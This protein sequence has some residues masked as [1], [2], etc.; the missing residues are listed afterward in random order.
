MIISI[1]GQA[2]SG[3]SSVA[4]L[5]ANKLGYRRYSIGDLR[6]KAAYERGI[7]LA[8]FN[9]LGEKED[10][11]DKD[12]DRLQEELG[13]RENNFVIDGRTSF[14]FIPKSVKIYLQAELETR[15]KRVFH[16]ER[17]KESFDTLEECKDSLAE[18]EKSDGMRYERYY[19]I[20]VKKR[21]NY[22]YWIE[23][24]ELYVEQVVEKIISLL[25]NDRKI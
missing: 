19:G 24:S 11:T 15:A 20:D 7:T 21:E 8:E 5:L 9:R 4:N 23:T 3:K 12:F 18:R 2:G 6:R 14:H 22:D 25:R 16:D 1:G 10:H 13:K 17:D